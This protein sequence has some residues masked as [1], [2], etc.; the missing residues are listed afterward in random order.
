MS[1]QELKETAIRLYGEWGWQTRL[2]EALNVD[3]S[4]VR[5]WTAGQVPVPGPVAAAVTCFEREHK[6]RKPRTSTQDNGP[7]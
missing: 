7:T 2:A 3:V 5:R 1:G 4:S 6:R